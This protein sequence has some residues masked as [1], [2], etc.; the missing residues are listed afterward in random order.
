[1]NASKGK[2]SRNQDVNRFAGDLSGKGFPFNMKTGYEMFH[3][4]HATGA[5]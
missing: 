3:Q 2:T 1:M 4:P 5:A